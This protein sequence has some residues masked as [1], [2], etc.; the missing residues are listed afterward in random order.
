[1]RCIWRDTKLLHQDQRSGI[2]LAV[3][4][5]EVLGGHNPVGI[6]DVDTWIWDA[7]RRC[8]LLHLGV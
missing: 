3:I 5:F 6:K 8:S 1:M 4:I 2:A 7:V